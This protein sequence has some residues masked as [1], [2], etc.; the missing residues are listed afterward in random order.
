M[1]YKMVQVANDPEEFS[2][3]VSRHINDGWQLYGD[4]LVVAID[5]KVGV[6]PLYCQGLTKG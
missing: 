3:L 1:Q 4:P 5:S 2:D 6:V